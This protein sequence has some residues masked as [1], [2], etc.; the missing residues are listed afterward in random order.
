MIYT[1]NES[2]YRLK[3]TLRPKLEGI[4]VVHPSLKEQD[5]ELDIEVGGE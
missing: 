5:I 1:K 3:E 4:E 2:R